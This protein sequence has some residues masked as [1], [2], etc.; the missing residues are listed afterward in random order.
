MFKIKTTSET[1]E[2]FKSCKEIKSCK[3]T[4]ERFNK[5]CKSMENQ[6]G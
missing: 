2:R 5:S 3:E 4:I 1:I 6:F